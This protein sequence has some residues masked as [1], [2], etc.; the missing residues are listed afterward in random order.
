VAYEM[1][2]LVQRTGEHLQVNVRTHSALSD[3]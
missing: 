2:V 3:S 1:A